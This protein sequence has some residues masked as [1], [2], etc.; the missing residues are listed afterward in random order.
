MTQQT[1]FERT[2]ANIL[3]QGERPFSELTLLVES[4]RA[5]LLAALEGVSEAQSRFKPPGGEG[6]DAWGIAEVVRHL[7]HGESNVA[8]RLLALALGQDAAGSTP[9]QLGGNEGVSFEGLKA[10][11]RQSRRALLDAV[12]AVDGV[13][14]LDTTAPHAYFGELNCRTWLFFQS[15]HDGLHLRQIQAAK[16]APGYPS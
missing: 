16:A 12:A 3:A 1:S 6:E 7:I 15:F 9:G 11:L 2:T 8:L 10:L 13:E 14:R 5:D 4:V